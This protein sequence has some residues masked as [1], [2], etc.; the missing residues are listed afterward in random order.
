MS[1]VI[2]NKF[3]KS[4]D[5]LLTLAQAVDW[6]T[7]R[8][9][10]CNSSSGKSC[11]NVSDGK[12]NSGRQCIWLDW[13]DNFQPQ[14]RH[15]WWQQ[16]RQSNFRTFHLWSHVWLLK[17]NSGGRLIFSCS[18]TSVRQLLNARVRSAEEAEEEICFFRI[19]FHRTHLTFY[20]W[21]VWTRSHSTT[22]FNAKR[23]RDENSCFQLFGTARLSTLGLLFVKTTRT[24]ATRSQNGSS[25]TEKKKKKTIF[26]WKLYGVARRMNEEALL[27]LK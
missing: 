14:H 16:T 24:R 17:E 8:T 19:V 7:Y 25:R 18:I 11:N 10:I 9:S 4:S 22:E 12:W 23:R 6:F 2:F 27:Q 13:G 26:Q 1:R 5:W 21:T 20:I 3:M 15:R